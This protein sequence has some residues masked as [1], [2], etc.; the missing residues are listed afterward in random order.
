MIGRKY[1]V[2]YEN[3]EDIFNQ[4][5]CKEFIDTANLKHIKNYKDLKS[6]FNVSI[7]EWNT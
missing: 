2:N 1:F 7:K 3:I 4:G 5:L 6:I